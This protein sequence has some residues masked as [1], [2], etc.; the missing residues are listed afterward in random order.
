MTMNQPHPKVEEFVA[1]AKQWQPEYKQLREIIRTFPLEETYKWMHPCYTFAGK[2]VVL[3]HGFKHYCALLFMKGALLDDPNGLLTQQTDAVQAGRQFRFTSLSA[4]LEQKEAIQGFI[5]R[6]IAVEQ[7]GLTVT[8]KT[9]SEFSMPKELQ[10]A[11]SQDPSLEEAFHALT[12][13]RQ[14]AYLLFFSNPKQEK[15]RIARIEKAKS[16]IFA[17]FGPNEMR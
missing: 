15:T 12:P 13:G 11:F 7:Q 3:I 16:S 2:N 17:G 4:I 1:K 10:D 14:R 8:M 9:T 6:A 5:E